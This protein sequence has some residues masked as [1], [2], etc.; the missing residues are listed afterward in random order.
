VN[1]VDDEK[2]TKVWV[3]PFLKYDSLKVPW[4]VILGN[5]DYEGDCAAEINYTYS[6]KNPEKLWRLP[7]K[8][9]TFSHTLASGTKIDFF[10]LDTNGTAADIV[11]TR[12]H[13][14]EELKQN[15]TWLA[16]QLAQ[17]TAKW[18][19]VFGHHPMYTKSTKHGAAGR[20]LRDPTFTK[21][22]CNISRDGFAFEEVLVQGKVDAYFAGHEHV[23][24]HHEAKGVNHFVCGASIGEVS[25]WSEEDVSTKVTWFD[26]TMRKWGFVGV[27]VTDDEM[28]VGFYNASG[29]DV[30]KVHEVKIT[31]LT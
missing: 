2:F 1:S 13:L 26:S 22:N 21:H 23:F 27:T 15:R 28:E 14:V 8:N 5:H 19:V 20:R 25:F 11:K 16:N 9:Y 18:K 4:Q 29:G 7:A 10:G 17:S 6:E 31:K 3:E 12:P 30:D 24:Q